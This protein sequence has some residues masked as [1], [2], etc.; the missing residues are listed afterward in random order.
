MTTQFNDVA[1]QDVLDRLVSFALE[2]GRFESVNQ[3]EPKNSP[4]TGV[5]CALWVQR[6]RPLKQSGLNSISGLLHITMRVYLNF[7]SEPFDYID[8]NITSATSDMI[9]R[10]CGDFELGGADNVRAIDLIGI[11]GQS[12]DAQAGYVEIDKTVFRIMTLQVPIIINDMWTEV[13]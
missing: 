11:S 3:H 9:G 10:L 4:G 1:V 12:I 13:A 2:S 5:T 6:I 8:P 7:R